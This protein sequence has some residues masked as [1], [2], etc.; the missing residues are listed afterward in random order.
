MPLSSW[1]RNHIADIMGGKGDWFTARLLR[2]II[3]A[4]AENRGKLALGFPEEVA[5]AED[6]L[7]GRI[8]RADVLPN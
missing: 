4:D 7:R 6:W 5:L 8:P 1:D 2:L 3:V